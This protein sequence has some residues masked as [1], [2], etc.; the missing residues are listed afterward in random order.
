MPAQ[1]DPNH[2]DNPISRNRDLLPGSDRCQKRTVTQ[3]LRS[4]WHGWN[5]PLFVLYPLWS[6][7][8]GALASGPLGF[9]PEPARATQLNWVHR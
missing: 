8:I 2:W 1:L 3:N 5:G 7:C 6:K 4:S 9:V